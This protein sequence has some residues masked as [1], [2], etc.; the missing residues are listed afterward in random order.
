M[1]K[2][3]PTT[4]HKNNN[5]PIP[6]FKIPI[7]PVLPCSPPTAFIITSH[8]HIYLQ[9][10][11]QVTFSKMATTRFPIPRT[12][13]T[14]WRFY[15]SLWEM[16]PTCLELGWACNCGGNDVTWPLRLGHKK[17][18]QSLLGP[19][20]PHNLGTQP[21]WHEEAP[22]TMRYQQPAVLANSSSCNPS[23]QSST[24]RLLRKLLRW[25]QPQ[26]LPE[27]PSENCLA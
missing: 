8:L 7:P 6:S 23:Q 3:P 25:L 10:V 9:N 27:T 21:L 26:L 16:F 4:P 14:M 19:L 11:W 18:M 2:P 22:A 20:G 1:T 17:T 24:S 12:F 5:F 15:H 13:L